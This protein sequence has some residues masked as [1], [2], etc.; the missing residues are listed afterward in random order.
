MYPLPY[1]KQVLPFLFLLLLAGGTALG[2]ITGKV[3]DARDQSAVIGASVSVKGTTEGTATDTEGH[4][5]LPSA[6][7]NA[8]VVVRAINYLTQEVAV[9]GQSTL[10][11]ALAGDTQTLNEVVITALGVSRQSRSLGYAVQTIDAKQLTAVQDPN[12][13]NNFAGKVAGVQI[14]NG[15]AGVGST[16]RIVIRGE[17]AFSGSNQPLFVVDGVPV[18]YDTYF[19]NAVGNS[20]G[21]G[22]WAEVDWGNGASEINPNDIEQVTVLKGGAAAALYGS[23]AA[24]GAVVLTTK[25]GNGERNA[26]QVNFTSTDLASTPLRLPRIQGEYG[27]GNG[28]TP[29]RFVDGGQGFENNIPNY[30]ARFDPNLLV[31]QF[32]SP[33]GPYLA[34]DLTARKTNAGDAVSPT[35]WQGHPDN[36][37][38]F[39]QTGFTSI[40]N[41]SLSTNTDNGSYRFSYGNLANRGIAPNADLYRNMFSL[42]TETKLTNKLTANSYLNFINSKSNE[43]PNI[44]YGSESVMYTFFGV[45]G[46]PTNIDL[47]ALKNQRWQAGQ[48]QVQ[49][50]RYWANHDNPYVTM[51]DNT[52]SF[53][54]NRLLGNASLSYQFTPEWSMTARTGL[55]F[56][57]D[58][59]EGHRAFST[60][61]FPLGGFRTDDVTYV[62][63]NTD[64]LL[65]YNKQVTPNVHF[66]VS[67]GA[68]RFI[69]NVT[70]SRAI[71]ADLITPGLYSFA[72]ARTLLP[73]LVTKS[74]RAIY[75]G[76]AFADFAYKTWLFLNVTGR[77]DFSSTLPSGSNSYFYPSASLSTVLSD[78]VPMPGPI[79]YLKVRASAAQV[80]RDAAPYS[81]NNTFTTNDPFGTLPLTTGSNVLANGNLK[82]SSTTTQEL[83]LDL[84]FFH[85][86]LGFDVTVYNS[87]TK[88]EIVQLP[89]PISS[90]YTNAFVNG[91]KINN[92]GIEA[93]VRATP[94]QSDLDGFKWDLAFN[95]SRNVGIVKAL[96]DGVSTYKYAEVTQYDRYFRSIQ[97]NAV[98]GERLGNLYGNVFVRDANGRIVYD[99]GVPKV[100]TGTTHL[101]GNYNPDFILGYTNTFS[102]KGLALNMTWDWHQG[103][104]IYSYTRLG[105]LNGGFS[106]ETLPGRD[107]NSIIGDGV[108][109][110]GQPNDVAV[111]APTYYLGYY[112]PNNNEVFTYDASYV[113]L[114]EL[115]LGYTFN[116][117]FGST[118]KSSVNV[119]LIGRNLLLFSKIKDVDPETLAL[120][121]DR[122]LPGIE[123][124][125]FPS[126]RD[127][128]VSVGVNF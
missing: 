17:N 46:M 59:R 33:A 35:P 77:N 100:T 1:M 116:H 122:I 16:A 56:Y 114:R 41:L 19:N 47:E 96:P 32:N 11:I 69:Q 118:S 44:G 91:G 88:D 81:V 98:V 97:Y 58:N 10:A 15:G 76:Y 101:L 72:N 92:R 5:S 63:N 75:S 7:R 89:I 83:G 111:S 27:A 34:G 109:G 51:Y 119:S 93:I 39:L 4:F 94:V 9:G 52:N 106:P 48:D 57:T 64:V 84:R 79:S 31:P 12:L 78:L 115:R 54:K 37:K 103:G 104:V 14:T 30:G 102:Y 26:L 80:G 74:N 3:V 120:R 71:A 67:G 49:Q 36:F 85:N 42:R 121:G 55:D 38:N 66:S 107:S 18:N 125:S 60:V 65:A 127:Y 105:L 82:P 8:T 124:N 6:D 53:K 108:K 28:Q 99:K 128:G 112:N 45:Y 70:Y 29:Y 13:V 123:F 22:T 87:D 40:N 90:G 110:D 117:L 86:R 62:E 20:S 21:R 68:N 50:F 43:R 23:R 2:Q 95:F 61:R 24:N 126:T 25:R 73:P 113:K